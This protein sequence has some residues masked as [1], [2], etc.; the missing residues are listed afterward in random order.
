MRRPRLTV[1]DLAAPPVPGMEI[2]LPA[3]EARHG[4]LALRLKKGRAV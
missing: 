3:A 2:E 4:V 1:E